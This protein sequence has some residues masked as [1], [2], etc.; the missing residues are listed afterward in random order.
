MQSRRTGEIERITREL[1]GS[2]TY[3][4]LA[5]RAGIHYST[6]HN[7]LRNHRPSL[8]TAV[9]IADRLE[10]TPDLR[11]EWFT[12]CGYED[13]RQAPQPDLNSWLNGMPPEDVAELRA[14]FRGLANE[15]RIQR[16]L[17]PVNGT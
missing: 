11:A 15:R 1:L 14:M 6:I 7:L 13:P 16:G 17:E 12:A 2:Q 4:D 5:D 3:R 9:K 10:L 8:G